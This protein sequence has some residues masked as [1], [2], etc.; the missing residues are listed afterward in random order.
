QWMENCYARIL[1]DNHITED[2]PSF[3]TKFDPA[4]Y[5]AMMKNAGVEAAMVYACC[6]NGNC[7]Y[8]TKVGHMHK[9]LNGRDIFGEIAGLLRKEGIVTVAYYTVV[10]HNQS[11]KTHPDWRIE[12]FNGQRFGRYWF[13]CPNSR[14]YREFVKKQLAEIL[15]YDIVGVFIDMTFW[16]M[17]CVCHNCRTRYLWETKKEIP[18]IIDWGS[19]EW[20][21][22][23]RAREKWLA[24]F[25]QEL[26]SFVKVIK[27]E[28]TVTHQFSP[29][30]SGWA[31]GQS[32]GL[33]LAS[34][35]SSGDFYGGKY[36]QSLGTKVFSAFSK[37]L[38]FEF[39]T[40]RCVN[41]TDHTSTKSEAEMVC[42]VSTT[43][44]NGG[45]YFFIDA[46]N[47][48]GT[49]CAEVY[50]RLSAV[51]RKVQPF[52]DKAKELKPV[53]AGDTGLYFSMASMVNMSANGVSLKKD[54]G[55][56]LSPESGSNLPPLEEILGTS[57]I[58]G[59]AHIPCRIITDRTLNF[60]N[61]KTI[62]V[63]NAAFMSEE[64]G[65]KL[66]TFVRNGGTLIATGLTSLYNLSG[67]TTGDFALK[68]I[69][70]VSY[71][72]KM[73]KRIN[74]LVFKEKEDFI[75]SRYPAPLVKTV[76]ATASAF[77]SEP[78]FDPDVPDQYASIHSNPPGPISDYPG[79]TVNTF[80]K[81][82]CVYL[83]SSLLSLQ[84]DAQQSF[85]ERLFK[86]YG[87]SGI[88]VST[89]APACV[90]I[91]LLKSSV[92]NVFLLCFVNYQQE[93]PN[94]PIHNLEAVIKLPGNLKPG[95]C[96]TVSD[97]KEVEFKVEN[98]ET[99]LSL[100]R[101]DTVEMVEITL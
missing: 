96:R 8:P 62:I 71:T 64:E 97:G 93:L 15:A 98:E 22:F 81:G 73:T 56:A 19:E 76:S 3:M 59:K 17:V 5:V 82:K 51:N 69:F 54:E 48:D 41:L 32:P 45:A 10:F 68:D 77:V 101:L 7:Y 67:K 2:D 14:E 37:H 79:L 43:L 23:Q 44:A 50:E 21:T 26:T 6:H 75:F 40:S 38:P 47:P 18:S 83:Y 46:I 65:G 33:A 36:Q 78:I 89:N 94:V 4:K 34:D 70:G 27:P 61:V 84:Q 85:G 20:V 91:T 95:S 55:K 29:V 1:V 12:D 86:E 80:G 25:G 11:S 52:R 66:R 100:A 74:Y 60:E 31:L 90:E 53:L 9:N 24:E 57:I 30:L 28:V 92:K 63:N 39:M 13:T 49:L 42:S 72:G 88:I 99:L 35:Y 58:L 87:P 16:P